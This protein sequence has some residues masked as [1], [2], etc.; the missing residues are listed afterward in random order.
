MTDIVMRLRDPTPR[1]TDIMDD[2]ADEIEQ[3]RAERDAATS[4]AKRHMD[5]KHRT[6]QQAAADW[7]VLQQRIKT[8]EAERDRLR[9]AVQWFIDNDDT[10]QGDEPLPEFGGESWNEI[11]A[12]WIDGLNRARAALKEDRT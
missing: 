2:A 6:Q 5:E 3:L 11:N 9:E 10:N 8:A 1:W 7:D 12:Y 4:L